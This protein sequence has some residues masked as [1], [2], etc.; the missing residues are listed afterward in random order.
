[1]GVLRVVVLFVQPDAIVDALDA[2][3][4]EVAVLV[5]PAT[6]YIYRRKP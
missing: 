1:M 5:L 3:A 2:L 4:V 6:D